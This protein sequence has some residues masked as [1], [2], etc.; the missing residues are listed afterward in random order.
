[1]SA[2]IEAPWS[3]R[4]FLG[5][6][7]GLSGGLLGGAALL[8]GCAAG[9]GTVAGELPE[10]PADVAEFLRVQGK[11]LGVDR[12]GVLA[13]ASPQAEVVKAFTAQFSELT[14]IE[15]AWTGLDEQSAA[16]RASV[17]LGSG[18]G[19]YDIV[20]TSSGLLPTYVERGWVADLTALRGASPAT[21]PTWDPAVYGPGTVA[22]LSQGDAL[23]AVPNFIGTQVFYYRTDVFEQA[24][25]SVPTTLAELRTVCAAVHSDEISAIA[26]RSA[27]NASQLLFV[28]SAWLYAYGG[29]F[30]TDYRDGRYS[31]V[32]LESDE[33][34][35]ALELYVELVRDYA[36]SGATNWSVE[37]VTRSFTTGRVAIVQEGAVFGGTF[38]DPDASQAAGRVGTFVIPS[39]PAGRF[40]PYNAHGWLVAE[41]SAHRDAAW[42][43]AQWAT[44]PEILTAATLG[45]VAYSTPPLP[46]VYRTPEYRD[47][48]G[49]DDFVVTVQETI[50]TA[51]GGG[52]TPFD[53][54]SYQ[55]RSADW[56]TVGQKI[57]EELSKAVTGQVD[58]RSALAAAARA[59]GS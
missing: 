54:A 11:A 9:S 15:V 26:L 10:L 22:M 50:E 17:A 20:Q 47:K 53:D 55:P 40:V 14:G 2:R 32:A 38:N 3:R 42:L 27:P 34:L 37:D 1:M 16:S 59:V 7:A 28:W 41:R 21:V 57:S 49:F 24:G 39:G 12:I 30:Y 4:R 8:G 25:V 19:G 6:A 35:Q 48:Y 46:K 18:A 13:Y 36:P 44:L 23:Y 33:A 51:D 52:Y 29:R 5:S 58:P 31:G 43:F 45:K 56:N